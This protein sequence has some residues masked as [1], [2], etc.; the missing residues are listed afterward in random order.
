MYKR[1]AV[2]LDEGDVLLS[3]LA[4]LLVVGTSLTFGRSW[5][6]AGFDPDGA[7]SLGVPASRSDLLLLVTIA[8]AVVAALPAVG[9]LLVSSI[10]VVP[11]AIARLFSRSVGAL[12][13][14]A[15][16]VAGAQG[17]LGLYLALWLDVPPGPA[18][19]VLGAVAYGACALLRAL[20]ARRPPL[21]TAERPA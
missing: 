11:A 10:F 14:T 5:T 17:A 15:V 4:C 21:R 13:W 18:V 2:G 20:R 8:V 1:Q 7:A 3:G 16:L 6:A 12:V 9:A 19:S